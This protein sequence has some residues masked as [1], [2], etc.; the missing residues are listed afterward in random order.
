MHESNDPD[1]H[2]LPQRQQP[3]RLSRIPAQPSSSSGS[4]HTLRR[5][6]KFAEPIRPRGRSASAGTPSHRPVVLPPRNSS[7]R[8]RAPWSDDGDGSTTPGP[9]PTPPEPAWWPQRSTRISRRTASAILY[10]LEEAIRTPFPFT[11]DVVEE[12][13][14]MAELGGGLS[15]G[16]GNGRA[17]NGGSRAAGG[18]VPVPQYS[19]PNRV[20]T[21]RDIMRR[22]AEKSAETEARQREQQEEEQRRIHEENNRAT[23]EQSSAGVAVTNMAAGDPPGNR[24]STG[25]RRSGANP[26]IPPDPGDRRTNDPTSGANAV[27]ASLLHT[28][29]PTAAPRPTA[30]RPADSSTAPKAVSRNRAATA[31]QPQPRPAPTQTSRAASATQSNQQL[32]SQTRATSAAA[33]T[34]QAQA[35]PPSQRPAAQQSGGS[36]QRSNTTSSFPHAFERWEALSSHWEGLTSYWIR[37]LQAN[38]E[39]LNGQ[40]LNQQLA[41]QVTDLSAAGA[42][43]FHAVVELQRLR[44][45]SERKFQRWFFETQADQEK[46]G[47][48]IAQLEGALQ[49]ERQARSEQATVEA[50]SAGAH[51]AESQL[52]AAETLRRDADEMKRTAEQ[53]VREMRRE[54][55][56]SKDEARRGWEEIGRMEQAERD[57]TTSL[58]NGEPTLVGGVQVVPMQPGVTSQASNTA[59]AS[60]AARHRRTS[61][62]GAAATRGGDSP[63]EADAGYTNYDP[64]R[65]ETDTDPFT[66]SVRDGQAGSSSRAPPGPR[67]TT[68]PVIPPSTTPAARNPSSSPAR[69]TGPRGS[70]APSTH[71]GT[72]LSYGPAGSY[73]AS[74]SAGASAGFY[75]QPGTATSLLRDEVGGSASR[76]IEGD[77]RSFVPSVEDT[78]SEED[79]ALDE[80]G[81]VRRDGLGRPIVWREGGG[82]GEGEGE[83]MGE[84]IGE[85]EDSDEYDVREQVERERMYG[86]RYGGRGVEYGS[87]STAGVG[88]GNGN[89]SVQGNGNGNGNGNGRAYTALSGAGAGSGPGAGPVDYS[90]SGYGW[91]AVPRHHNPTRLSDVLEEDERSRTSPSRASERSRGMR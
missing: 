51:A 45:S 90:G 55:Q 40:P 38:G 65:S 12:S 49:A 83:V 29:P 1:P 37:R 57:R 56:I 20:V 86:V 48:K 84:G 59:S 5:T 28:N 60:A 27:R 63:T 76:T 79:Y 39:E 7:A 61:S 71:G 22:R 52:A 11:P 46:T 78:V 53:Q 44:A 62:A 75:Q 89:G 25:A 50:A 85:E 42:N 23:T 19:S 70:T 6:P 66:E 82:E 24:A 43:L 77:E 87:G 80:R 58:R 31:T 15:Q 8:P 36:Q 54:L 18:P 9:P 74:S 64:A 73:L 3:P 16:V 47:E 14:S 2:P 30:S 17:Q 34:T 13:A 4:T 35:G 67:S 32:A 26:S 33:G 41:R 68:Y 91:E 81:E 10:A 21:P 88:E 69:A 72:F